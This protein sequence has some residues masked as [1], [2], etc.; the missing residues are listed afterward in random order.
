VNDTNSGARLSAVLP[1]R[2]G[3]HR[4]GRDLQRAELLFE[5]L[6]RFA[7]SDLFTRTLVVTPPE[8]VDF[9]RSILVAWPELRPEFIAET[10]LVPEFQRYSG[11]SGWTKQQLLKLAASRHIETD[12]YL[13][14]DAD[15][16]CTHSIDRELLLPGG[17]G[18]MQAEPK[19]LH[20]N[21][22]QASARMLGVAPRME[23]AGMS[24][25]PALLAAGACRGLIEALD[26]RAGRGSWAD[27]LMRPHRR[28]APQQ[29][30]PNYRRRYRWT[31]YTLYFLYCREQGLLSVQHAIGGSEAVPQLLISAGSVWSNV[32]FDTWDPAPVFSDRDPALFCVIQSNKECDPAEVRARLAPYMS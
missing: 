3:N 30:L 16:V 5:S 10:D 14:L 28:L 24:V 22:W 21:W 9:T 12:Y 25:T 8:E 4:D 17:R 32:D 11:I 26:A 18:L 27:Y 19:A 1:L 7:P 15:I 2:T 6:R 13:T 29:L 23:E 31:E 20:P